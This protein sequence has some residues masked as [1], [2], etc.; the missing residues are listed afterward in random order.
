VE[1]KKKKGHPA[2]GKGAL[3]GLKSSQSSF[4]KPQITDAQMEKKVRQYSSISS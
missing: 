1:E 3:E 4:C 2:V